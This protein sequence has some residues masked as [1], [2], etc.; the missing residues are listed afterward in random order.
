MLDICSAVGIE[1]ALTLALCSLREIKE[2][3]PA[4]PEHLA[5]TTV[6]PIGEMID[7]K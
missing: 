6:T 7:G 1:R 5:V 4:V 2:Y 3:L